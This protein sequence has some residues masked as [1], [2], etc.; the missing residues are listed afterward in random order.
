MS[1]FS[2]QTEPLLWFSRYRFGWLKNVCKVSLESFHT[3][4]TIELHGI[5]SFFYAHIVNKADCVTN[6]ASNVGTLGR[7]FTLYQ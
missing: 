4:R 2:R 1:A 7:M 3:K 6:K 5:R